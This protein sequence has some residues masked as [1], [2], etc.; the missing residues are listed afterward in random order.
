[1][2]KTKKNKIKNNKKINLYSEFGK[3]AQEDLAQVANYVIYQLNC[4]AN[5]NKENCEE[6]SEKFKELSAFYNTLM[7][8][9]N[10]SLK[11]KNIKKE[12][13]DV[14]SFKNN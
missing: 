8:V 7:F 10:L 11:D 6:M 14:A 3:K 12:I 13:E 5:D 4:M 2:K 1:M 9:Y